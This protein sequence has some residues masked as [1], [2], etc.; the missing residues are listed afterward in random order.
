MGDSVH[1][2]L[3]ATISDEVDRI[4]GFGSPKGK[5][6][7]K[8]ELIKTVKFAEEPLLEIQRRIK[9]WFMNTRNRCEGQSARQ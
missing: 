2:V 9:G 4:C 7:H 1:R 8:N 6:V 3:S 5:P